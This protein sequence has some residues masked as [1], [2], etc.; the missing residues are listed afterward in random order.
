MVLHIRQKSNPV[1]EHG[2]SIKSVPDAV[3]KCM[4][5]FIKRWEGFSEFLE[6]YIDEDSKEKKHDEELKLSGD[7]CAHCGELLY[8][9]GKCEICKSCGFSTCG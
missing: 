6:D 9:E 3:A 4:Q 5:E 2:R 8:M 1:W 7:L